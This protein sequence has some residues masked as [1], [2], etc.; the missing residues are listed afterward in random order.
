MKKIKS[1]LVADGGS[2]KVDWVLLQDNREIKTYHTSG[3]NPFVVDSTDIA[4]ELTSNLSPLLGEELVQNI[5]G[6]FFY[7]A[8]C[9]SSE[10]CNRVKAGIQEVFENAVIQVEHDM[11]GA[12]KALCGNDSG[13]ACI[14]GTGSNCCVYD[15]KNITDELICLGHLAGDEGSGNYIGKMVIQ[16]YCYGSM[17]PEIR[18]AFKEKYKMK[19]KEIVAKLYEIEKPN[20][21]LATFTQF[22]KEHI[23]TDYAQNIIGIAFGD[24]IHKNVLSLDFPKTSPIHFTGSVA[25]YFKEILQNVV[26]KQGLILGKVIRKPITGMVQHHSNEGMRHHKDSSNL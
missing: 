2:T 16:S 9:S 11:L 25:F 13:V 19:P 12:V 1:I 23:H 21:Y 18:T 22:L 15:G 24:F 7:G 4:K 14:L 5:S 3:L 17:P 20:A 10:N 26:E 8:G 6:I